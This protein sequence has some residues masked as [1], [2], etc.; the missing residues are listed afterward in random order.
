MS[1]NKNMTGE[2]TA[3]SLNCNFYCQNTSLQSNNIV[4]TKITELSLRGPPFSIQGGGGGAVEVFLYKNV[5]Q[6]EIFSGLKLLTPPPPLEIEWWPP[7]P[8][9]DLPA[10]SALL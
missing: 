8:G 7:I 4:A 2:T 9:L 1:S 3:S 10:G 6:F 5:I